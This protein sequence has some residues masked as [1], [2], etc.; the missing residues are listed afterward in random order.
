MFIVTEFTTLNLL[1][2]NDALVA[3]AVV[4]ILL[5]RRIGSAS[6]LSGHGRLPD[7]VDRPT[8]NWSFDPS[9]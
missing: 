3:L 5:T 4:W 6:A 2:R 7:F 8:W 1:F 9:V